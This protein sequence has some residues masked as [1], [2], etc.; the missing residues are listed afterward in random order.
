MAKFLRVIV[1]IVL[2]A[3]ILVACAL[4]VPTF[5]GRYGISTVISDSTDKDT[6]LP[7]GSVAYAK[8]VN[9]TLL[10]TGDIIIHNDSEGE[11][12]YKIVSAEIASGSYTLHDK[13]DP[14]VDDRTTTLRNDIQKV[15]VVIPFIGYAV[16]AMYSTEGLIVIG[17]GILFLIILFI[18]SELWKRPEEEDEEYEE[19]E[20]DFENE[21]ERPKSKK[22]IKRELKE[23]RKKE[24]K[25]AKSR[26]RK[27]RSEEEVLEEESESQTAEPNSYESVV[28]SS[29]EAIMASVAGEIAM[30][31]EAAAGEVE[32]TS[33]L[34]DMETDYIP[35]ISKEDLGAIL[36]KVEEVKEDAAESEVP[37]NSKLSNEDEEAFQEMPEDEE[38]VSF[39]GKTPFRRTKIAMPRVE[40]QEILEKERKN[41]WEPKLIEDEELGLALVD[42]TELFK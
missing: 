5:M 18:L 15:F 26:G 10:K 25:K 19:D 12:V 34:D 39:S 41:N 28:Q 16:M 2:L 29:P 6:N 38:A 4:L 9:A 22:E 11:N 30:E 1:N 20:E 7:L 33:S 21:E 35:E 3:A 13:Y 31:V 8:D 23:R 17:L 36:D 37:E 42:Y 40:A 32:T 14:A 24:K 27:I